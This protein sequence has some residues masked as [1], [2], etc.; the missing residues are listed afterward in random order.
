MLRRVVWYNFTDVSEVLATSI[1]PIMEAT[2]T[3][4]ASVNFYQNTRRN[5]L[6]ESHHVTYRS[7]TT[8]ITLNVTRTKMYDIYD[9]HKGQTPHFAF[10]FFPS[11]T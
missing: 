2:S 8:P 4:E 5:F 6:Q 1:A 7:V 10:I 3:S 9:D 11:F